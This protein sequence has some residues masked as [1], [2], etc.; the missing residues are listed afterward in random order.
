MM[1]DRSDIEEE[2]NYRCRFN[3]SPDH[4]VDDELE[5]AVENW[6]QHSTNDTVTDHS[7]DEESDSENYELQ[8]CSMTP[9]QDPT[10]NTCDSE[11]SNNVENVA[12][13]LLMDAAAGGD[14][15]DYSGEKPNSVKE[16]IYP[17][18][19]ISHEESL[20][21]ILCYALRHTTTKSALSDLLDL[22]NLHCPEGTNGVPSSL[23]KFL[24]TFDCNSF[25]MMYICPKCHHYFGNEI[26]ACCASCGSEPGDKKSLVKSVFH[27]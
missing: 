1:D 12:N 13:L 27:A 6:D 9:P 10:D 22:I 21:S 2:I 18:A 5:S 3:T 14:A 20:L 15:Q 24:K 25:E 23:Y 11:T 7:M 4:T 8:N 16:K 26:P 19:K 17:N